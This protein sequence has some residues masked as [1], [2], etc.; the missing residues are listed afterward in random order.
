VYQDK[1][2]IY[3][4]G[5]D[6]PDDPLL[7][8]GHLLIG[9]KA[10]NKDMAREFAEWLVGPLG[11]NIVRRFKKGE[12]QLYSPAPPRGLGVVDSMV[13]LNVRSRL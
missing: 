8:P 11:Q 3:T 10:K 2:Q 13:G 4:A 1:V 5:T 9:T 7:L 12:R 6:D